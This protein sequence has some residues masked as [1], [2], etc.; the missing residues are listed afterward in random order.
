MPRNCWTRCNKT[1]P[2]SFS[3][4]EK[5][6]EIE[7]RETS[8]CL[9]KQAISALPRK[10]IYKSRFTNEAKN[11]MSIRAALYCR[12]DWRISVENKTQRRISAMTVHHFF[13]SY[14][15]AYKGG[16]AKTV[17]EVDR[18]IALALLKR[19]WKRELI[20]EET[21]VSASSSRFF[22]KRQFTSD[23]ETGNKITEEVSTD[24]NN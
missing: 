8:R 6:R 10:M 3:A 9:E 7:S 19:L 5:T 23:T 18:E 1:F 20:S 14:P 12:V 21:Y 2:Y 11:I 17:T 22:D 4:R 24:G 13:G 16:G 15:I